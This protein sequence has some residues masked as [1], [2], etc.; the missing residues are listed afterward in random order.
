MSELIGFNV[1]VYAFCVNDNKVLALHE[2]YAGSNICKL[3][4]GGLE[5]GEGTIDCLH[6]EFQEELNLKIEVVKH[7]YTQENFIVSRMKDNRQIF[8]IYYLVKILNMEELDVQI[9]TIEKLE[10]FDINSETCPLVLPTD[11]IAFEKLKT[12]YF[13]Q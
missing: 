6:R 10:W 4:G 1:R 11:K 12:D 8:T 7:I 13:L 3:P 9:S 5:F 2:S